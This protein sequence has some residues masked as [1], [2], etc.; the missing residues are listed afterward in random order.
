MRAL[1]IFLTFSEG[2]YWG[3][4]GG[5]DLRRILY[6]FL[7]GAPIY[8]YVTLSVRLSVAHHIS[9]TVHHVIIIFGTRVTW[10]FLQVFFFLFSQKKFFLLLFCKK[11]NIVNIRLFC[12]FIGPLQQFLNVCFPSSSVTAKKKFWSVLH[13]HICEIFS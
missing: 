2:F 10:W 12:F 11:C 13:L 1:K 8:I 3:G 5:G 9:G 4:W 7:R 6:I